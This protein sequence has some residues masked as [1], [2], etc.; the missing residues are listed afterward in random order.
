LEDV[1]RLNLEAVSFVDKAGSGRYLAGGSPNMR[2][3]IARREA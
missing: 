2:K 1:I 3:L